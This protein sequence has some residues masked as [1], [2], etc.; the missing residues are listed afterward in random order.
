M[1]FT[2]SV[3]TGKKIAIQIGHQ[4]FSPSL[5]TLT[6]VKATGRQWCRVIVMSREWNKLLQ[7]TGS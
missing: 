3:E 7:Q 4:R 2:V 5:V 6:N 1:R